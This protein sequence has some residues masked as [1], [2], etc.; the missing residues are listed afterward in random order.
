MKNSVENKTSF[1]DWKKSWGF[2]GILKLESIHISKLRKIFKIGE[3][4]AKP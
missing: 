4:T 3:E 1:R 2:S